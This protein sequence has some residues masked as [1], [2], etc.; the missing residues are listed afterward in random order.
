MDIYRYAPHL[1]KEWQRKE[2]GQLENL[3]EGAKGRN[4]LPDVH[5]R[6]ID[7]VGSLLDEGLDLVADGNLLGGCRLVG[8]DVAGLY[9]SEL[10]LDRDES[11]A[12]EGVDGRVFVVLTLAGRLGTSLVVL[13]T[14]VL[15]CVSRASF[16]EVEGTEKRTSLRLSFSHSTRGSWINASRTLISESLF[17]RRMRIVISHAFR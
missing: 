4:N 3:E 5:P 7:R 8:S 12:S 17:S 16:R 10:A 6:Q 11:L 1:Q 13:R 15:K 14:T 2:G 9:S